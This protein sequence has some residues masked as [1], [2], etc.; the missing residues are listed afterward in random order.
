MQVSAEKCE[1]LRATV[2]LDKKEMSVQ[3]KEHMFQ[4]DFNNSFSKYSTTFETDQTTTPIDLSGISIRNRS[5]Y[6]LD[7]DLC[8]SDINKAVLDSIASQEL[9]ATMTNDLTHRTIF[10]AN[11]SMSLLV[12]LQ[13]GLIDG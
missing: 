5:V 1:E 11:N 8:D 13:S 4:M 2:A 7:D 12:Q 6:V 10:G 3:Q 9:R